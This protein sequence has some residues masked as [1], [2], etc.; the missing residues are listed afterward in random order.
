MMTFTFVT[1]RW[2]GQFDKETALS[3][4][5]QRLSLTMQANSTLHLFQGLIEL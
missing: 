5:A 3:S 2:L 1:W 4:F